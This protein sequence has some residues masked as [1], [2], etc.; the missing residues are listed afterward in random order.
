MGS[1]GAQAMKQLVLA[2]GNAGKLEELRALLADLPLRIVAQGELG[3]DDVPETGLT[4]VENALIKA[5]HASAV[6]GLPALADDSGLIVDALDGAPGL[7]SARYAG[8]PTN[9]LANNAKLLDAMRDV[10]A[11]RR[12]A[13]FYSVIVLLRHPEDPQP[14]IAEGSWEGVITTEPRGDGGFGYNPVFLD[15]VYGLTA[16][17]MDS[18]LKNRLSHRAVALATLLHKL[19][20][21]SL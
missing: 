7:Y 20:A 1:A 15:P 17:E 5:R 11:D 14:L 13:R 9:A 6:T 3:V 8:S 10:P 2:S 21:L 19:H 18:A 12:S 16:A 4:F